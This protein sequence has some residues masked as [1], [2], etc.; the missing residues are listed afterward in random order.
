MLVSKV[1]AEDVFFI[2]YGV[3]TV[4]ADRLVR[5]VAVVRACKAVVKIGFVAA[6]AAYRT[7]F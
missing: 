4:R 2:F 7:V 6:C 1:L 5:T 3:S